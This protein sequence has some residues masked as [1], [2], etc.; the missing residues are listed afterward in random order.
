MFVQPGEDGI[1]MAG[2]RILVVGGAG[3]IGGVCARALARAGHDVVTYDD[4]STGFAEAVTGP[5]VRA[6][7][8]DNDTLRRTLREGRFD[9]VMHFASRIAVGESVRKPTM[10]Y[11]VNVAGTITLLEA[12]ADAGV[13]ALVFSSSAAVYGEPRELPIPEEH[14][15]APV[16]P[17]GR[18][19]AMVEEMLADSR[20]AEGLRSASLRYFNAAGATEDGWLGE[21]HQPETHLIPLAIGAALGRRP[22]LSVFGDDYETRDGTCVRDYIHV[23]DLAA[24]HLLALDQL[25]Q[26]SPGGSWNV[27]TGSGSTVYEVLDAVE[28]T[29]GAP[30]PREVAPRR[31]GDPPALVAKADRIRAELGWEPRI[32]GI[33]RI[34]ADACRW[35]RAP[36]YGLST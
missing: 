23:E 10:Y 13:R 1:P 3:Y 5:L 14:P 18:T 12:M 22:P 17:Y 6:D 20:A 4:L 19:K 31:P 27:G 16:S 33:D 7:L 25:L 28:A 35:A 9:A 26:G 30:V 36:R 32:S 24:A 8:R 2:S 29:L 21:A 34:V 11:G 15:M